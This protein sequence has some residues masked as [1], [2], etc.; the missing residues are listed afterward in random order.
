MEAGASAVFGA[1]VLMV[2]VEV[3]D[4][5]LTD[6]GLNLQ[7]GG[8]VVAGAPFNIMLAQASA[9][10]WLNPP[11]DAI[12][13]VV[14]AAPPGVTDSCDSGAAATSKPGTASPV[15]DTAICCEPVPALSVTIRSALDAPLVVGA[16]L[17]LIVQFDVG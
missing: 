7:V 14:V 8:A 2:R 9:T 16:N 5:L 13:T 17:T 3:P 6:D 15:P 1:V 4:A 12:V 11:M 10:L